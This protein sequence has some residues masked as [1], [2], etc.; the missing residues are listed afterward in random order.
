M[1]GSTV[2]VVLGWTGK[3]EEEA[4]GRDGRSLWQDGETNDEG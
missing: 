1:L 2:R 3:E 4:G